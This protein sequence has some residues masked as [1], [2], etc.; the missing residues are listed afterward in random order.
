MKRRFNVTCPTCPVSLSFHASPTTCPP[1]IPPN[2]A[3]PTTTTTAPTSTQT[4]TVATITSH[5]TLPGHSGG[6]HRLGLS[7]RNATSGHPRWHDLVPGDSIAIQPQNSTAVVNYVLNRLRTTR[8]THDQRLDIHRNIDV[9]TAHIHDDRFLDR[10]FDDLNPSTIGA[11]FVLPDAGKEMRDGDGDVKMKDLSFLSR[12]SINSSRKRLKRRHSKNIDQPLLTG[13]FPPPANDRVGILQQLS[14][15]IETSSMAATTLR[16]L[17]HYLDFASLPSRKTLLRLSFCCFK[18]KERIGL[19]NISLNIDL[20]KEIAST[21]PNFLDVLNA[22]PSCKPTPEHLLSCIKPIQKRMYSISSIDQEKT[23]S[24]ALYFNICA[25][26]EKH[27]FYTVKW[28]ELIAVAT[29]YAKKSTG[30]L[31]TETNEDNEERSGFC[32]AWLTSVPSKLEVVP[33]ARGRFHLPLPSTSSTRPIIMIGT[34]TGISPFVGFL[35]QRTKDT[36]QYR[37]ACVPGA[38]HD[39]PTMKPLPLWWMICGSR[40]ATDVSFRK[41]LKAFQSNCDKNRLDMAYS[42]TRDSEGNSTGR[43][44]QDVVL[45]NAT[46]IASILNEQNGIVYVCGSSQMASGVKQMIQHA[47][48]GNDRLNHLINRRQYIE[49]SWG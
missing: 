33:C 40:D 45:E 14:S 38:F 22:F 8:R 6:V 43:Y 27:I 9:E 7:V 32:S 29:L 35:Q 19:Q 36:T 47:I 24:N 39:C 23:S 46:Q 31:D 34:G 18:K 26:V 12:P 42:R 21:N 4:T 48:G 30:S 44:V 16:L 2:L 15:C 10:G 11:N 28:N 41:E 17:L 20:Y 3:P 5:E 25:R 37:M 49:E 1:T 13:T